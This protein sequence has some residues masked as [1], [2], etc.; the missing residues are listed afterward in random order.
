LDALRDVLP[1][2]HKISLETLEQTG[3]FIV[4]MLD[5]AAARWHQAGLTG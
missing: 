2:G 4:V 1:H 5:R 3:G